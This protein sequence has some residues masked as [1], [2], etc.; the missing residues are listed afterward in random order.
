MRKLWDASNVKVF[1]G[2]STDTQF[3]EGFSQLYGSYDRAVRSRSN[4]RLQGASTSLSYQRERVFSVDDLAA[5]PPGR[6]AVAL[7]GTRPVLVATLAW[8]TRPDANK[9]RES[10]TRYGAPDGHTN[11][12]LPAGE[13]VPS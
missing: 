11:A 6:A 4:S 2:G 13:P 5:M 8:M 9:V 1:A 12:A 7:S 3:L 10:L